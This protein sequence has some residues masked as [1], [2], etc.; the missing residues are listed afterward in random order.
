V[1]SPGRSIR[2]V[3][4]TPIGRLRYELDDGEIWEQADRRPST[5]AAA[6]LVDIRRSPFGAWHMRTTDGSKR[7]VRV[8]GLE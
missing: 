8:R 3:E 1:R 7:S 2:T 4:R 6:D 5:L